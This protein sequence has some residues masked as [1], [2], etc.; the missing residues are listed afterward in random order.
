MQN[1][2]RNPLSL[3]VGC[4]EH[5]RRAPVTNLPVH[6]VMITE[7]LTHQPEELRAHILAAE[8]GDWPTIAV[9]SDRNH[10]A[11]VKT[12][13]GRMWSFEEKPAVNTFSQR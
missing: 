9:L 10:E 12:S 5:A 8:V 6:L 13:S 1:L 4:Q 2:Q 11:S 3:A 7:R